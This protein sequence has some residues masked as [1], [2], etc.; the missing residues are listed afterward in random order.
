MDLGDLFSAAPPPGQG[1]T[2]GDQLAELLGMMVFPFL[3]FLLVAQGFTVGVVLLPA[4]FAGL[5]FFLGMRFKG[6]PGA[7]GF[8]TFFCVLA[9]FVA[10]VLGSVLAGF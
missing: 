9:C 4:A 7:V 6:R 3:T 1:K 5:T 10:G 2:T 8:S